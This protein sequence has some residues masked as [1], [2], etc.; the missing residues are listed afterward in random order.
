M[1]GIDTIK[2]TLNC[3][4]VCSVD[5]SFVQCVRRSGMRPEHVMT[6]C[7]V[8]GRR[9]LGIS[10]FMLHV[11]VQCNAALAFHYSAHYIC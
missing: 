7:L 8:A 9:M 5:S 1:V 6:L 10:V 2:T 3:F 11:F 4:S